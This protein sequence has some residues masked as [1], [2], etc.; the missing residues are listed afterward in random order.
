MLGSLAV[1]FTGTPGLGGAGLAEGMTASS[2][3]G[4]Q[5]LAVAVTLVWSA[6]ATWVIIKLLDAVCRC[7]ASEESEREGL[8]LTGHGERAYD[9]K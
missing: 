3:F 9:L 5:L 2:Q 6:I 1:A 7:R 4:A 8:D